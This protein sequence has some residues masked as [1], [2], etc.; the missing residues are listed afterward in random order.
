MHINTLFS[1]VGN[2]NQACIISPYIIKQSALLIKAFCCVLGADSGS[3]FPISDTK[4]SSLSLLGGFYTENNIARVNGYTCKWI[5]FINFKWCFCKIYN[6]IFISRPIK[7]DADLVIYLPWLF[8]HFD[9]LYR[10]KLKL[11][12]YLTCF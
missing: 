4:M 9:A 1:A 8:T 7:L 10:D 11:L 5:G 12:C 2:I 3:L 6:L